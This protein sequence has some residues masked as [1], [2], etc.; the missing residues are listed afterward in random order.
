[1]AFNKA[2]ALQ[3][4]EKLV[5]Q[6]KVSQAIKQYLEIVEKDPADLTLLNTIG[7][8]YVREKKTADA[9]KQFTKLA[10]AFVQEGFTVK[11]IAIYKKISK[12]DPNTVETLV[13]LAEL[14]TVQGLSR[15][16]REQYALAVDQ[17]KKKN[18]NDKALEI[19]R[20]I[21]QLDPENPTFRARLAEFC[22]Q[23][24][25]KSD[26]A[27][28]YVE[29]AEMAVRRGEVAVVETSLKK[30][31]ALD[32]KNAR[33]ALLQARLA[34]SKHEPSEA[35]RIL[36]SVPE[37][38]SDPGA[39]QILLEVYLASH[40]VEAAEELLIEVYRANPSDF[41]P[42]ASFAGLCIEKG[43]Y[44]AALKPLAAVADNL[45]EQ[46]NTAP[47]MEVLRQ[48]WSK[49]PRHVA[50][51]ELIHRVCERTADESTLPE[52][53]EALGNACVAS[54]DL[55]KAEAAFQ[56]LIDREPENEQYKGLLK[57]VMKKQ[58]KEY[59][60]P[61]PAAFSGVE[62]ALEP[63][64]EAVPAGAAAS[65]AAGVDAEQ[66][67]TVKEALENS[68]LYSRY[69]LVDKA[70][71]ELDK[72]LAI[73]PDQVDIHQRIVEIC[74]R[75]HQGRAAQSAQAL[76]RILAQQGETAGARKYDQMVG[77][78][79]GGAPAAAGAAP[80]PPPSPAAPAEFDLA[81]EM[82]FGAEPGAVAPAAPQPALP[83][84]AP[85]AAAA[86]GGEEIDL[87][88]DFAAIEAPGGTAAV[89]P[90][91]A[92]F[93][94]EEAC[95]EIDFYL[96]QGFT[97][98]AKKAVQALEEKFAGNPQI[99]ELRQRV[100]KALGAPA[101]TA[102]RP[103]APQKA[104]EAPPAPAAQEWELPETFAEPGRAEAPVEQPPPSPP[105]VPQRPVAAPGPAPAEPVAAGADM[106]G[107]LAGDLAASLEGLEEAAPPPRVA[108][109]AKPPARK[110]A[111][112]SAGSA[113]P[114]SGLLDDLAEPAEAQAKEEDSETHYNLGVA[115]REMGLLDEA[116]GEFQTV[117]KGAQKGSFPPHFLQSCTLLALCF[118]DKNMPAIATKW[119]ARALEMP[120]LD[121]EAM[122]ALQYDLGV[123]YEQA[124]ETKSALEKFTEVYSQNIDYR[125][126][127][128]KIRTLQQKA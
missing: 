105:P 4:A 9:L 70:L 73:Y 40:K 62:M 49:S 41:S 80:P 123:A 101:P 36:G 58:G 37:L 30:A 39:R 65:A 10:E 21:V 78:L 8:L 127:A 72:V 34:L 31:L 32:P 88:G 125:D 24:G 57:Q 3:E 15:E 63:E 50:T 2:K 77:Q 102:P 89:E 6:G 71:V 51:L 99:A 69:G 85:P 25:R 16:A 14:Y 93:N 87:S 122:L 75:T 124:G 82:P 95:V 68:D 56:K 81:A 26:A 121:E 59:A 42:M 119:Y 12:L 76:S 11:A 13:K 100:A 61:T 1:M 60:A 107:S 64:V 128:E 54:G 29:S 84:L 7:D 118:M 104:P 120:D 52:V 35:E 74:A 115:F 23:T 22:E 20:K 126:V 94:Y 5:A 19:L 43:D 46:K 66:A 116:I 47:L 98:E 96:E 38:K 90:A 91:V 112:A 33:A 45:I 103:A 27:Q 113:S 86:V 109:E 55:G 44:D 79:G 114:L 97:E 106:L 110:G 28:A 48:I 111:Q 18:Q 117:L 67:A 108:K 92:P 53:L 83:D 17:Y